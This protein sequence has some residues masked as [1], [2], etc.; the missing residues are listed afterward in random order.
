MSWLLR[1]GASPAR[2]GRAIKLRR[3]WGRFRGTGSG[4]VR[5]RPLCSTAHRGGRG[6]G[7]RRVGPWA[8]DENSL[9]PGPAASTRRARSFEQFV[10]RA[11]PAWRAAAPVV[12]RV[13]RSAGRPARAPH[14]RR[15]LWGVPAWSSRH[16]ARGIPL[17]AIARRSGPCGQPLLLPVLCRHRPPARSPR[18]VATGHQGLAPGR[19]RVILGV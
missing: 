6:R 10:A 7:A 3:V 4:V 1:V 18:P 2:R 8:R 14:L 16:A 5:A 19:R 9:A 17:R 15:C 11:R 13:R 12:R